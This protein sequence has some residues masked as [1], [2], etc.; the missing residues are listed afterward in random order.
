MPMDPKDAGNKAVARAKRSQAQVE[1]AKRK[2]E[3]I[4]RV[5]ARLI[6]KTKP[7]PPYKS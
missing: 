7:N 3:Q 2:A 4:Q 6:K 5:A 1:K